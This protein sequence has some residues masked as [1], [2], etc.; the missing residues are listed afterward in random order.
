MVKNSSINKIFSK[1]CK[2]GKVVIASTLAKTPPSFLSTGSASLDWAIGGG[3]PNGKMTVFWGSQGAGKSW[4]SLKT[5][6]K[7]LKENPEKY[8]IWID[9]EFSFDPHRAS[10]LGVDLDRLIVIQGNTPDM[11]IP[12]IS[13]TEAEVLQDK[14]LCIVVVDSIM[15]MSSI[16]EVTQMSDGNVSSAAN[17]YG[18]IAKTINVLLPIL[19]R[20][21]AVLGIPTIL[22]NHVRCNMDVMT[23]K[24]NPY[25]MGGGEKLKHLMRVCCFLSKVKS[26]KEGVGV[27]NESVE[28]MNG[29]RV[30]EGYLIRAKVDK[31]CYAVEGR[32]AEFTVNF[33][34]GEVQKK[35]EELVNLAS[36]L[37]IIQ[38]DGQTHVYKDLKKGRKSGFIE[39]LIENPSVYDQIL[40]DVKATNNR[41]LFKASSDPSTDEGIVDYEEEELKSA[42]A[43]EEM[44]N[45]AKETTAK[46]RKKASS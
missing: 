29:A 16:N 40:E 34:L 37:K 18:G 23:A 14:N 19:G 1:Y 44:I 30:M 3:I 6:A 43:L 41:K 21:S 33:V 17:S 13:T 31:T 7:V 15:G 10:D 5:T 4:I 36:A 35:E 25:T 32:V 45:E 11:V 20:W 12:P 26:S 8:A 28:S 39:H 22:I 38:V 46:Y 27:V 2:S 9:T 24:Y 42:A